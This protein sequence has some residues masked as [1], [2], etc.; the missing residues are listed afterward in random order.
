MP[1][2]RAH[3]S[4][5]APPPRNN[6]NF[7]K[8]R[9]IGCNEFRPRMAAHSLRVLTLNVWFSERRQAERFRGQ[10]DELVR[11][12]PDVVCLQEVNRAYLAALARARATSH[13]A[14]AAYALSAPDFGAGPPYG[15]AML[16][17][18]AL[19]P[20]F[21]RHPFESSEMG[22]ELL[23]A[24]LRSASLGSL[25]IGCVHLES[26]DAAGA[27]AE[28]LGDCAQALA[29][30]GAAVLCGD[31]NFCSFWD[32]DVM[33]RALN[34]RQPARPFAFS[35]V[36]F[37]HI[38]GGGEWL[39]GEGMAALAAAG[40][41]GGGG[42]G[43]G[44]AAAAAA[45]ALEACAEAGGAASA[46]PALLPPSPLLLRAASSRASSAAPAAA[47]AAAAPAATENDNIQRALPGWVDAWPALHGA[48]TL[49][50][51]AGFTFDS[52]R[53]TMLEVPERMR[54]DRVLF[55]LPER[56]ALTRCDLVGAEPIPQ[57]PAAG[58]GGGGG[59]GGTPIRDAPCYLSDHFGVLAEWSVALPP[60]PAT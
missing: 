4:L 3:T 53:N 38:G 24:R 49:E 37:A 7:V 18:E 40:D 54:Y 41:G 60:R 29:G 6:I 59:G 15:V 43:G 27:R 36:A 51:D 35:P 12:A 2:C 16:V 42:G 33:S 26:M 23:L 8:N 21:S 17:R 57:Q 31:L 22:R 47:A 50:N 52:T 20:A 48:L 58:G 5:S 10:F 14:L 11:L 28:Q 13:P 45:A 1:L 46:G 30:E 19:A 32:F 56:F 9:A 34:P 25:A 44:S 55:H 39:G